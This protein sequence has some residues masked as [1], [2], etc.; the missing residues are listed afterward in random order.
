[1]EASAPVS[2]DQDQPLENLVNSLRRKLQNLSPPPSECCIYRVPERLRLENA[3][4]YIPRVLSIGPLHH[5]E[6]RFQAMEEHKMLYLN[7]FLERTKVSLEDYTKFIKEREQKVRKHYAETFETVESNRFVEMILVDAAFVIELLWR[8]HSKDEVQENDRI[9][10]RPWKVGDIRYDMMLLENQ[11]PFFIFEDIFTLAKLRISL[12]N[13]GDRLSMSSEKIS[14]IILTYKF[15]RFKAYLGGIK[16]IL[17]RVQSSEI[18]HFVDFFRQCHVPRELPPRG[19]IQTL[20]VPSV[21]E[22]YEAGVNFEVGSTKSLFD[23]QFRKGTLVIPRLRIRKSTESFF[24]NLLAFE[25]CHLLD[26]YINDY[27]F[28]IDRLIDTTSAVQLLVQSGVIESKLPDNKEVVTSINNLVRGSILRC[29]HFYFNDL[30]VSLNAYYS[31]PWNKWTAALKHKHF[32]S[33]LTIFAVVLAAAVFILTLIQT[34]CSCG[35][36]FKK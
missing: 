24:L 6:Q 3:N 9:F 26:C 2:L 17:K 28:I 35:V 27:V 1:M 22:L 14:L 33:P 36:Q 31:D 34:V 19:E 13:I 11:L 15:F 7:S 25:Q 5:G 12:D 18:K 10:N 21:T 23:I 16:E 32:S 20:T 29:K 8:N 4:A 30:C